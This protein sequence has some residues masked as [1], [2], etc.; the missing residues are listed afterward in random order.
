ML[1]QSESGYMWYLKR[2]NLNMCTFYC[3]VQEVN[4]VLA[5]IRQVF[6]HVRRNIS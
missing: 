1:I 2:L 5:F 3:E 4:V 6:L